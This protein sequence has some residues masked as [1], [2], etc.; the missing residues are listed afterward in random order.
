M[1]KNEIVKRVI[2]ILKNDDD[3]FNRCVDEL[4]TWNGYADDERCYP[5][6]DLDDL[7]CGVSATELLEKL[8]SNF[9]IND[10]YVKFTIWGIE[11]RNEI[12]YRDV[13]DEG[14]ILD[15][16]VLNY[17]NLDISYIDTELDELIEQLFKENFEE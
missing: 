11:S 3:I 7:M 13:F 4:D 16:L 14:D 2:G 9:D 6:E 12:D 8:T 17:D 15:S 1:R 5:M 10:N